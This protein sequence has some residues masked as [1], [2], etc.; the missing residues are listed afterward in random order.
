MMKSQRSD[1]ERDTLGA[2]E[3]KKRL[4]TLYSR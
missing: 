4:I 2:E 3:L 1:I